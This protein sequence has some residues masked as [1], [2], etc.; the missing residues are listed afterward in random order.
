MCMGV[1]PLSCFRCMCKVASFIL[2]FPLSLA[3]LGYA[4]SLQLTAEHCHT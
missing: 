1:A 2:G 4:G 3:P